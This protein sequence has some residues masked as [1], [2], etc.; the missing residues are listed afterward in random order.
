MNAGVLEV[1]IDDFNG[2]NFVVPDLWVIRGAGIHSLSSIGLPICLT[3]TRPGDAPQ[4]G[5]NCKKAFTHAY[6]HSTMIQGQGT[7]YAHRDQFMDLDP[8]YKDRFGR[9]LLRITYDYNENDRRSGRF[10]RDKCVQLAREMGARDVK[11]VALSDQSYSS[12]TPFDSSHVQGGVVMGDDPKTSVQN[13]YQQCWDVPNLFVVGASS[14]PN[15]A[16]YN[17]TVAVGATTLWTA[18]AIIN[19]Y[20]KNTKLL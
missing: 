7:G 2:D 4:W 10:I 3:G 17:P 1:H 18:N 14:F 20:L 19:K 12:Y 15:N 13:R 9:P 16:G 8:T 11:G 5:K 6:Q